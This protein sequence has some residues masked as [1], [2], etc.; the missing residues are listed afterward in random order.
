[1]D[2]DKCLNMSFWRKLSHFEP[3]LHAEMKKARIRGPLS[4]FSIHPLAV[5]IQEAGVFGVC[6]RIDE[7][8]RFGLQIGSDILKVNRHEFESA[9]SPSLRLDRSISDCTVMVVLPVY[10]TL[11]VNFN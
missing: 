11:A 2:Y 3:S 9:L 8:H 10:T 1:M 5:G 6:N 4:P 7:R